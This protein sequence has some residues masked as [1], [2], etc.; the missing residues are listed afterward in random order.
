MGVLPTL[1]FAA[2]AWWRR[3]PLLAAAILTGTLLLTTEAVVVGSFPWGLMPAVLLASV[4]VVAVLRRGPKV[5]T[6][7]VF[8]VLGA[9]ATSINVT[10]LMVSAPA[11]VFFAVRYR[12]RWWVSLPLLIGLETG[13]ALHVLT[14]A[15]YADHPSYRFHNQWRL[16]LSAD[17]LRDNLHHLGRMFGPF[18]LV[19]RSPFVPLGLLVAG[20]AVLAVRQHLAG[21]AAG[22][23]A[24]VLLGGSLATPKTTDGTN[25]VFFP[26][27]RLYLVLPASIAGLFVFAIRDEGLRPWLT[28][29]AALGLLAVAVG[30]FAVQQSHLEGD[31][32]ALAA[33]EPKYRDR[34]PRTVA[35]VHAQCRR[36]DALARQYDVE[37]VVYT[38][39]RLASYQCGAEL[40][41][42]VETVFP[43]YERR[44][45]RLVEE[46]TKRR[47]AM[48]MTGVDPGICERARPLVSSCEAVD[49][50]LGMVVMRFPPQPVLDLVRRL[51]IQVRPFQ[52][53]NG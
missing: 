39:D 4:G 16:Y 32:R 40:Y 7:I 42:T 22:L 3:A 19:V 53:P 21:I 11:L 24:V 1:L 33:G 34:P 36:T 38:R 5:G 29:A 48:L 44:T 45:W 17:I 25:S 2:A 13:I 43:P 20:A 10:S 18:G 12:L 35:E 37:L 26:Y 27:F 51:N 30:G 47:T 28:R 41:E 31:A 14:Q 49:D 50:R 9:L 52:A 46:S 8:A 6:L 23:T 15:F